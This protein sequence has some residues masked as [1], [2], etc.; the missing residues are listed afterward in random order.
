MDGD[1]EDA[2][3][4]YPEYELPPDTPLYL[5]PPE[6]VLLLPP[7]LLEALY[8]FALP[9]VRHSPSTRGRVGFLQ[10]LSVP[11]Q[12]LATMYQHLVNRPPHIWD[13]AIEFLFGAHPPE[14]LGYGQR[15]FP[16]HDALG[17]FP[18]MID[19][20]GRE[21]FEV[22]QTNGRP[23]I[24]DGVLLGIRLPR[25]RYLHHT[26]TGRVEVLD[27]PEPDRPVTLRFQPIQ[28]PWPAMISVTGLAVPAPPAAMLVF[29]ERSLTIAQFAGVQ[30]VLVQG[31]YEHRQATAIVCLRA[32]TPKFREALH[33]ARLQLNTFG[34]QVGL[35]VASCL[36]PVMLESI[37]VR[38][39]QKWL[40]HALEWC[41]EMD[42]NRPRPM[43]H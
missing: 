16:G 41:R 6:Q 12:H 1:D 21:Y 32:S 10:Q 14:F 29:A 35:F 13:S 31:T 38:L 37:C 24:P 7:A 23:K 11:Q 4:K 17:H 20:E 22:S 9:A 42:P 39:Q 15:D 40:V 3:K 34:D 43:R 18:L 30:Q 33:H 8:A 2:P 27:F 28:P 25:H 19:A 26:N 5:Q 36:D